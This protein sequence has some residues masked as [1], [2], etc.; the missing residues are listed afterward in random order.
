[1]CQESLK[2]RFF[3]FNNANSSRPGADPK[4]FIVKKNLYEKRRTVA[5]ALIQGNFTATSGVTLET[6]E[7]AE[8]PAR[9][10]KRCLNS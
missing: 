7:R 9:E 10:P 6:S 2:F 3:S 5:L 1:M 8:L 4:V